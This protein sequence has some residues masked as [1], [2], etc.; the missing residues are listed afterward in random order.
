MM[1]QESSLTQ[2]STETAGRVSVVVKV[3]R[4]QAR[5]AQALVTGAQGAM[6]LATHVATLESEI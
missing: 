2:P 4:R 6:A 3:D 5:A 1:P